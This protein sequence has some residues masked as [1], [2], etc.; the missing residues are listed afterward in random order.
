MKTISKYLFLLIS[1]SLISCGGNEEKAKKQFSYENEKMEHTGSNSNSKQDKSKKN[2][3]LNNKGI[4]PVKALS[5]PVEINKAL[6]KAGKSIFK[7]KCASCHR[8]HKKFTGPPMHGILD[9]RSPEWVMN[10]IINPLEMIKKDPLA[11]AAFLEY[12][13]VIMQDQQV[14]EDD[15]RALLEYFRTLK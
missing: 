9:R 14:S 1:L 15:A 10:M 2:I 3:D 5:I 11:K 6:A 7:L 4:G 8:T 13:S 12:N